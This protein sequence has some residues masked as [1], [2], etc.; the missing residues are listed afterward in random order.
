[1]RQTPTMFL[2]VIA[3]T[4]AACASPQSVARLETARTD[5][6]ETVRPAQM[7]IQ[8]DLARPGRLTPTVLAPRSAGRSGRTEHSLPS[9]HRAGPGHHPLRRRDLVSSPAA[10]H[11]LARYDSPT[12]LSYLDPPYLGSETDYGAGVFSRADFI[13]LAVRLAA[14]SGRFIM[15]VN[16]V[17]EMREAFARFAIESVAT[18]HTVAGGKWSDVAEIVVT[19]PAREPLAVVQDLLSF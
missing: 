1:M 8:Y 10:A 16:D 17:P 19:G 14:I 6:R 7:M 11:F 12:T 5:F 18:R 9:R 3:G 2:F 13:R 4:L 15:S